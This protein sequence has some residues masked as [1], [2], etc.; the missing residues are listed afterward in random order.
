MKTYCEIIRMGTQWSVSVFADCNLFTPGALS[1]MYSYSQCNCVSLI[2]KISQ[3]CIVSHLSVSYVC[4]SLFQ[5]SYRSWVVPLMF[6]YKHMSPP[7]STLFL[8][9]ILDLPLL[10]FQRV[11]NLF[12]YIDDM[13]ITVINEF[14]FILLI[15]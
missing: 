1:S 7:F 14:I 8:S 5:N 9:A 4:V 15:G 2:W 12:C 3:S 13:I 11:M 10:T 6:S